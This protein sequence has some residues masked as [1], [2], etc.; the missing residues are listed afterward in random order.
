MQPSEAGA[1]P[2]GGEWRCVRCTSP[3]IE[4][5]VEVMDT[6]AA[7]DQYSETLTATEIDA[8]VCRVLEVFCLGCGAEGDRTLVERVFANA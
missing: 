2:F 8:D 4:L 6:V 3:S 7:I 5:A 1:K